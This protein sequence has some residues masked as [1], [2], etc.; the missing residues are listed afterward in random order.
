[1]CC[2]RNKPT[3]ATVSGFG[4]VF[5]DV[6][7]TPDSTWYE[8]FKEAPWVLASFTSAD[9]PVMQEVVAGLTA[10]V[11]DADV[12]VRRSALIALTELGPEARAALPAVLRILREETE[13][14]TRKVAA[15]AL[16]AFGPAAAAA[17]PDLVAALADKNEYTREQVVRALGAIGPKAR[18]AVPALQPFLHDEDEELREAAEEAVARIGK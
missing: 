9:D 16:G 13:P 17:V 4:A 7:M 15:E 10:V 11:G 3:R 5:S 2:S 18:A 8:A 6:E 14:A 12:R 1:M